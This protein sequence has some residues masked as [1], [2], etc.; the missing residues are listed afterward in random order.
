MRN[1]S[2]AFL[3]CILAFVAGESAGST[4]TYT[5]TDSG[6]VIAPHAGP[7]KRVRLEVISDRIIHVTSAP[8]ADLQDLAASLMTIAKPETQKTFAV[9]QGDGSVTLATSS[10]QAT[11][12]LQ[13]GAV[14][15]ADEKGNV[16]LAE[17]SRRV[18]TPVQIDGQGF[19][20]IEQQFNPNTQEA[21]YGLGQHQNAQMNYN[22]EDVLLAQHN[23]DVAIPFV[24]SDRKY[25]V[26]WD[27]NSITRFGNPRPYGLVSRDLKV[28]DAT[29]K[30]G[31][32]TATYSVAGIPKVQRVEADINYHYIKDLANRPQEVLGET[33]PNNA[34]RRND[35]KDLS[36]V[37]EGKLESD[38]TGLHR[39]QLYA[40]SY[41]KVFVD[42]KLIFDK[43]RQNW[44]PWYH[45][46]DVPMQAGKPIAVRIEWIPDNSHIALLHNDP[47]PESDRHSLM[48]SSEAA[49]AIDYYYI[50]GSNLDEVIAG[51]RSLTGKAVM[52]PRWA[53]GFWQS[54]QRYTTQA[55]LLDVVK[56]YRKRNLPL[57]NVVM[58][59]FYW[60]EDQ[61][62]SHQ[63]DPE[64]FPD[65][66]AMIDQIHDLNAHFMIS[67]WPK[68]YPNTKNFKELDAKGFIYKRNIEKG[69]K[70]WVGEGHLSSF[71][72][73]YSEEA[74]QI[75]WRQIDENL[76]RL[77]VDAWWLDASEP[78]VHSNLD[79]E[80]IKKRIG[81]TALGP[82]AVYFNSYP[83]VHSSGVYRGDRAADPAKRVFILTR[84]SFAGQ[85]RTAAATWSGDVASRWDDLRNQISA[86]VNFSMSGLPNWTF[87]IGGFALESRYMKP[88]AA[89]LDEW[90]ELNL[91]WFQFGAFAPLFR[92]HGEFP[93]RE[94]YNLAP[95][96]SDIYRSLVSYDQLRYRL[97]PYI[98][99]LAADTHHRD[100]IIMRGLVM[101]F[102]DPNVR[103][104]N[105]E[106]LFGRAFLVSPVHEY[107][108]RSRKVYLPQGAAWY[109][110]YSG[111]RIEGGR[112]ID[113]A[114]PL[115]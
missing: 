4:S 44:N 42:G 26:L 20:S 78:D 17:T 74:R 48:L 28:Y 37:W 83:L 72:D 86:G 103:N 21:F 38:K 56:E 8:S 112:S 95:E 53:Y 64:R 36:V 61:W 100:E 5:E 33:T 43:W 114:A 10:L 16:R 70:D 59:W 15:F 9:K 87:D 85:Q 90:R 24:V 49:H 92:S 91:R 58:D 11:V 67:V 109:D 34:P 57:D 66:K 108:A 89:D 40:G 41:F 105:D 113:A 81:P 3:I 19:Y 6:V 76:N 31:G 55:E 115:A 110:F 104:I 32:F 93:Y 50:A 52:L 62:G 97:L 39:F 99:T 14:R 51:Y 47:L 98:Y 29:G 12:S 25:G 94:I 79:P 45:N 22:G 1:T 75:Y 23:M 101:D 46:F 106:Y 84:S 35:I 82:S 18:L 96:G 71:Y 73:P 63:F 30:L 2:T 88:S 65:P 60:R 7:A 54:R 68:F 102:A 107:K 77:G 27:N 13:D 80:E 69:T 111:E